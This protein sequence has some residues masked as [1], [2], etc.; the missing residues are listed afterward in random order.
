MTFYKKWFDELRKLD[1]NI[2]QQIPKREKQWVYPDMLD[3]QKDNNINLANYFNLILF[4]ELTNLTHEVNKYGYQFFDYF[5][6]PLD[7]NSPQFVGRH[8]TNFPKDRT[9]LGQWNIGFY[10]DPNNWTMDSVRVGIGF[11]VNIGSKAGTKSHTNYKEW[12][13][14]KV[15]INQNGFNALFQPPLDYSEPAALLQFPSPA[16]AVISDFPTVSMAGDWRFFGREFKPSVAAD[17]KVLGSAV[18]LA[19]EADS[20]FKQIKRNGF[21]YLP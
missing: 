21:E 11:R 1:P 12:V 17:M 14:I 15:N 18:D 8:V 10:A 9:C 16:V 4:S 13:Y 19:K 6:I 3:L 2:I 5:K 7:H 20:I